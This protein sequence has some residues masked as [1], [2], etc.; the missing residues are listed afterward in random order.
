MGRRSKI[1]P[2]EF[3]KVWQTSDTLDDVVAKTGIDKKVIRSRGIYY[4]KKGVPLKKLVHPYKNDWE[5]LAKYAAE[6]VEE[7]IEVTEEYINS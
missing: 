5:A 2:E 3:I 4:V 6:F 1:T 7:T